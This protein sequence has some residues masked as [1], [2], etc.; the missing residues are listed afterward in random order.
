MGNQLPVRQV[1]IRSAPSYR[2]KMG[3]TQPSS[4]FHGMPSLPKAMRQQWRPKAKRLFGDS[5]SEVLVDLEVKYHSAVHFSH[6]RPCQ[7][8]KATTK[9]PRAKRLFGESGGSMPS[10]TP[11]SEVPLTLFSRFSCMLAP[12]PMEHMV[13]TLEGR[14]RIHLLRGGRVSIC[15]ASIAM[16][17]VFGYPR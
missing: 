4:F 6:R 14:S 16:S 17:W 7:C 12:C 1:G 5:G 11:R 2:G 10:V 9:R 3:C 8:A 15:A 13:Q